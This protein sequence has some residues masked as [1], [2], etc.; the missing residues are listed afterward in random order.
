M[1]LREIKKISKIEKCYNRLILILYNY[2]FILFKIDDVQSF[3]YQVMI[4]LMHIHKLRRLGLYTEVSY[5][6]R[7]EII[8]SKLEW[9][10]VI[11]LISKIVSLSHKRILETVP[12]EDRGNYMLSLL[13]VNETSNVEN[14]EEF[15]TNIE[16]RKNR[17]YVFLVKKVEEN[18]TNDELELSYCKFIMTSEGFSYQYNGYKKSEVRLQEKANLFALLAAGWAIFVWLTEKDNPFVQI[19]TLSKL[20]FLSV[21]YFSLF[22]IYFL[23]RK[24]IYWHIF[25][26]IICIIFLFIIWA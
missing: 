11:S 20:T 23:R 4:I 16:N 12:I 7:S 1:N 15:E 24:K 22:F 26:T 19:N 18:N 25:I 2:Y 9:E 21:I 17:Y 8:F 6:G 13:D 3:S 10:K 14:F 5:I